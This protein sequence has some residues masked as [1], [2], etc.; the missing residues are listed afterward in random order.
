MRVSKC[1]LFQLSMVV[2]S[3]IKSKMKELSNLKCIETLENIAVGGGKFL[4]EN[5]PNSYVVITN[6]SCCCST[7]FGEIM[8]YLLASLN[9]YEMKK[10]QRVLDNMYNL[11]VLSTE[12]VLKG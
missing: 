11:K 12:E 3:D 5:S 6:P 7:N 8:C 10:V 1:F 9:I 4:L 2:T